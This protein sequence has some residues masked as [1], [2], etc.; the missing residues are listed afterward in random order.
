[1]P[2]TLVKGSVFE[3]GGSLAFWLA[4][5]VDFTDVIEWQVSLKAMSV[6]HLG[7]NLAYFLDLDLQQRHS[8]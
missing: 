8:S 4:L 2:F 1:M 3:S 6:S 5:L 7:M